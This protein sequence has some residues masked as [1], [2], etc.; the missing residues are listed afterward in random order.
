MTPWTE[1]V[2]IY[3]GERC[4]AYATPLS[5]QEVCIV[6]TVAAAQEADFGVALQ[7]WPQLQERLAGAKLSS[8]ERGTVTFH[9]TPAPRC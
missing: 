2:K 9:A 8:R 1:F 7:N 4:Q 6:L 5:S 3:W